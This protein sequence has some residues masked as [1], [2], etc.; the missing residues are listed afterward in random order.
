MENQQQLLKWAL[1][2]SKPCILLNNKFG[3]LCKQE[4]EVLVDN[5]NREGYVYMQGV[6]YM[7]TKTKSIKTL[8]KEKKGWE[9]CDRFDE[10]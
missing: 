9:V 5:Q 6:E 7:V 10:V 1:K 4:L 8:G 2:S 3:D